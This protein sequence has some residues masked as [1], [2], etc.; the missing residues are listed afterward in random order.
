[1]AAKN[2]VK[3][4]IPDSFYHLYN[5]GVEKRDIFLDDQD[6][7]VFC[8]YLKNYLLPKDEIGLH[9]VI[10]SPSVPSFEKQ[11]ALKQLKLRNFFQTLELHAFALLPNHFHL[12]V[13]QLTETE[14]DP[15]MNA[16]GTRYSSY[17]NRRYKR[18]GPLFQGVYKAV[19]V[20]TDEQLLHLSRY[21]HLNPF[22]C[23][24]L[25]PAQLSEI[26]TPYSLPCYLGLQNSP[27]IKKDFILDYFRKN[28][29][30]PDYKDFVFSSLDESQIAELSIDYC[31][32]S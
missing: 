16:I 19:L 10:S 22:H 30:E 1:M 18:I 23:F 32:D 4:Y 13:R 7:Q 25:K 15:F 27:W 26:S 3:T 31:D 14:I 28:D 8:S 6:Y 24:N 12:L 20:K 9:A 17:F 11:K 2:S 5:R 21:I 29:P